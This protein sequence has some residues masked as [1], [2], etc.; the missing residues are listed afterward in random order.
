[1]TEKRYI[2]VILPLKLE[3]E[4]CYSTVSEMKIGDRVRV[5]FSG[6]EYI[7]TVSGTGIKPDISPEKIRPIV[8]VES[9]LGNILPQEIELWRKVA[10]YY[11][12]T[13]G[14]VYRAAY[15]AGK[16]NL[17]EARAVAKEKALKRRERIIVSIQAR[18]GRLE[19]RLEKKLSQAGKSK[20]G[21]K[22][23]AEC[24]KAAANIR[25]ELARANDTLK[26]AQAGKEAIENGLIRYESPV[27]DSAI[28]L[29]DAQKTAYDGIMQGFGDRRPVMLHGVTGSGKTE[30]YIK[31]AQETLQKGQN[32]LYLV[33]EIA[34][35]RQLEDRLY[36]HFGESLMTFHSGESGASRMNTAETIRQL[37]VSGNKGNYIV[38]GTRSA[39]FL[40]HHGLGL[41][42]VDE[43][44]DGSYKQDSP[45]PRYNGRD[46]ALMLNQLHNADGNSCN[47]ILGSATPSLEEL[48]N[49]STGRHMLVELKERYHGSE[50]SDI[51][52]IDTRAERRKRGMVGSISRKLIDH[53][54]RTLEA[55]KQVL[56]LRSRRAWSPALQCETCGSIQK[57]PHCNVSLS[58][59]K[60]GNRLVCHYFS[61]PC[62]FLISMLSM[63]ACTR[64]R[65]WPAP[66]LM[67]YG[68]ST[69]STGKP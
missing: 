5:M 2:S 30:I 63:K 17:E 40:P 47:I 6:K 22:I 11:M 45:A 36:E 19:V 51:E 21:T 42:I 12:C 49:C 4:P 66:A 50:D 23:K 32:V 25:E 34:L 9:S 20:D 43:E 8:S 33:P 68:L 52:I 46:T 13:T 69:E 14:E 53:I 18:I 24:L 27:L 67:L 26:A 37:A 60:A 39:L 3:W 44:H 10:Q 59:H 15:P 62:I 57:C 31:L 65:I 1:M 64:V 54:G 41:I 56:I 55:G 35:S 7:G 16:I 48:Y 61:P 38:L 29:S 58:W 28:E